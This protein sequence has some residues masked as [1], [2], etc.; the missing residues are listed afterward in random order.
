MEAVDHTLEKYHQKWKGF[1]EKFG[2][3]FNNKGYLIS[4]L[5]HTV[6]NSEKKKLGALAGDAL[7]DFILFEFLLGKGSY[8]RGKMDC[9]RKKLNTN[10]SLAHIGRKMCLKKYIIFPDSA[11]EEE[12]ETSDAYY[13]D[14]IEALI[15]FIY[16]DQNMEST[17][18]FVQQYIFSEIPADEYACKND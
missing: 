14:T 5:D 15:Y 3:I 17:I 1:E 16:K 11:T 6:V 7:L 4:A 12:K 10:P 18:H 9:I 13:N 2:I 8:T